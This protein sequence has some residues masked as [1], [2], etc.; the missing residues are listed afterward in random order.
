MEKDNKFYK[1]LLISDPLNS[2]KIQN[3]IIEIEK[4]NGMWAA[5]I[6]PAPQTLDILKRSTFR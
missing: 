6:K 5:G 1:R 3:L 2:Q 4:L